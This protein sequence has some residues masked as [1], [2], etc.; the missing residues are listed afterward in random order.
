MNQHFPD[1]ETIDRY[2]NGR[3][4]ETEQADFENQ[5][6]RNPE[7]QAEVEAQRKLLIGLH[8]LGTEGQ[9]QQ[10]RQ[11]QKVL[12]EVRATTEVAFEQKATRDQFKRTQVLKRLLS[13]YAGKI[14]MAALVLVLTGI[15]SFYFLALNQPS[16]AELYHS[17]YETPP[18][19]L[20]LDMRGNGKSQNES[21][22]KIFDPYETGNYSQA[23]NAANGFLAKNP[24][25][26]EV[27]FYRGIIH[28]ELEQ[29]RKA[30]SDLSAATSLKGK[31]GRKAQWYL[32]LAYL[33]QMQPEKAETVLK[34]LANQPPAE[35][36]RKAKKLLSQLA[37]S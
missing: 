18:N 4:D 31:T 7:W 28:L 27:R 34:K 33:A 37:S 2:L 24:D 21:L 10:L 36:Q 17:Y 12:E 5:M 32:A 22:K 3:M 11:T 6:H 9:R 19:T 29:H 25:R 30:L 23:L 8:N 13:S 15:G 1:Y 26:Q 20:A 16:P 35:Y 14:T